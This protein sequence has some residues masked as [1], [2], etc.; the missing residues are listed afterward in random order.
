MKTAKNQM[1]RLLN[2]MGR[3]KWVPTVCLALVTRTEMLNTRCESVVIFM[4]LTRNCTV[5]V[6]KIYV[7]FCSVLLYLSFGPRCKTFHYSQEP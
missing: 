4:Y 2:L 6:N 1:S 3:L 5:Y 7:L